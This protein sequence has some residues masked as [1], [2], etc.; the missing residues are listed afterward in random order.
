MLMVRIVLMP[1]TVLTA[2]TLL[3]LVMFL[4]VGALGSDG[5]AILL[6]P[7]GAPG[8]SPPGSL[9]EYCCT[10]QGRRDGLDG[11]CDGPL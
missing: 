8:V 6:T 10:L 7:P 11:P 3:T 5:I 1:L 2:L 4:T 9:L